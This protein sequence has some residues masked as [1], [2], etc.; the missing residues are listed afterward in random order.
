MISFSVVHECGNAR[1]GVL[2]TPHGDVPTPA[3]MPVG[4]QATVKAMSPEE[5]SGS[6]ARMLIA[7]TYHLWLRPGPEVIAAHGGLHSF[8]RW[9]H[10]IA[11]DSGGYQAFSLA[12]L[13]KL[14]D[15]GFEFSSHLDGSRRFLSPEE[16]MR[17]QGL[18]GSD[19]ALQLDVCPPAGAPMAELVQAVE[20]TTRWA[21]RC[22]ES[23]RPDQA[24][25]GIVQGGTDVGLRL[26]HARELGALPLDGLA[27]GGFS[28]GEAPESMH[29]TLEA[30]VPEVDRARPRYLMGVGTPR[31]LVIA[32]GAGVDVFDCVLP[33]RNARNGQ[34]FVSAGRLVV[35]NARYREDRLPLDP[36]CLCP[37]CRG[38]YSRSYLRH[39]Y[40]AGEILGHRLL[41]LHNLHFFQTLVREARDAILR[42]EYADFARRRL[43]AG[44][45]DG[46]RVPDEALEAAGTG[47]ASASGSPSEAADGNQRDER[48]E[49]T[50]K[51]RGQG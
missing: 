31:D 7:N 5:V 8:M 35:K 10:A 18:L 36:E 34:A 48:P 1:A 20:R 50:E 39:L 46:G 13:R 25:F 37:V 19:I 26:R 22:L 45:P 32:I 17:V 14:T 38:G 9:P 47:R 12:S 49:E 29:R 23:R 21:A 4:T 43:E 11:T 30:V 15:D 28:V 27:L 16:A 51:S 24:L 6:G 41:T 44:S 42:G 3:F 40:V 2:R 33:T